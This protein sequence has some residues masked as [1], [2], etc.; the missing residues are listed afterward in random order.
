MN[1]ANS[2]PAR[3]WAI[4]T[5]ALYSS[6]NFLDRQTLA[7]MA[8]QIQSEFQLSNED[9][10]WV[11][12]AFSLTYALCSPLVGLLIDRI[13][14][15]RGAILTILVWSIAGLLTG[16]VEGFVGLLACRALLGAAEAGGIPAFAKAS[17]TYLSPKE[18]ALGTG[19]NQLG[20][21]AGSMGA[22]VLAAF[23]AAQYGWRTAFVVA[24]VLGFFWIP[25]W[26][27]VESRAPAVLPSVS[28]AKPATPREML[29][30]GRFWSLIVGNVL[31]MTVYSLWMNWTT[32]FFVRTYGLTQTAA[33]QG[34]VWIPP[35][36]A[37]AGGLFGGWLV[38]RWMNA[39]APV[40]QARSR[41][42]CMGSIAMLAT[43]A[44]PHMP[45]PASA[46]AVI[47]FSFFWTL[48]MSANVY[49]L[50]QDIFG[51]QRAAFAVASIT[52]GYGMMQTFYAPAVG[53]MVDRY[54]FGPVCLLT[55]ALPFL[56]WLVLHRA[57]RREVA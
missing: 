51:P 49:A 31:V 24:G 33:N 37:T 10:G 12:A 13:G 15:S 9:I 18:R 46:T 25:L 3:W 34:Y 35:L 52:F 30:D 44:A 14:L 50:P 48:V 26:R 45:G 40:Y 54:G 47:S 4:G 2:N 27:Y 19:I 36:F 11:V 41:A 55:A 42:L 1:S 23:V 53:R 43:I 21:S 16:Y 20:I 8:P 17:A 39:G 29:R 56:G 38:M 6:L 28:G 22:P 5:F 7:A 57:T 32:I